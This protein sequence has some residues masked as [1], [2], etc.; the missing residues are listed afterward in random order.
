MD[1][2]AHFDRR[3]PTYDADQTH[4]RIIAILLSG[5]PL[6]PGMHGLDIATGTGAA[7]L[8]A[9]EIVG[10]QGSVL[11]IDI[12]E[13][14]LAEARRKAEA[15]GLQNVRFVHADA[16]QSD[17]PAQSFDFIF[18]ASA[19][20]LMRDIPGALRRWSRWLRPNGFIAFD[21]PAKPFGIAQM[22][23]EA[24]AEQG[25]HL[26]YDS[27]ADTP[28]KCRS[29][30]EQAGLEAAAVRTEVAGD[31]FVEVP[32]AIAFLDERL[33]HPAWRALKEA[34]QRTRDAI[35][36]AL[37]ASVTRNAIENRVPNKVAQNFVY[38]RKL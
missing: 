23:A 24:A 3:G 27:I 13:G 29:L 30:L 16:E 18:C 33:D 19:L 22:I 34:S 11:G 12:S 2:A 31:N 17:L 32:E 5:A 7:A 35:R 8:K 25:I 6:Q 21:T 26:P 1:Q 15:A 36:A 9:A 14:M 4:R 37:I 10:S 28:A 20:V 38:G